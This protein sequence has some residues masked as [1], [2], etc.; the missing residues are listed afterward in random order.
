[1]VDVLLNLKSS[2]HE[3]RCS[4]EYMKDLQKCLQRTYQIAQE[5]MKRA[6]IRAKGHYDLRVRE[7]VPEASDLVLVKL[8]GLTGKHKLADKWESEPY[9]V[10]R[11][12]DPAMPVYV[13]KCCDGEG[14]ERALHQNMFPLALPQADR[15]ADELG[16]RATSDTDAESSGSDPHMQTHSGLAR[17]VEQ[18]SSESNDDVRY[19]DVPE[20]EVISYDSDNDIQPR[21][22]H[23]V[24]R[25]PSA[26]ELSSD[27]EIPE[28]ENVLGMARMVCTP[29]QFPHHS[30]R[31]SL[32]LYGVI[33]PRDV[34]RSMTVCYEMLISCSHS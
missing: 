18:S 25:R 26:K 7:N 15:T 27:D 24:P 3:K 10:I 13:V 8:V 29:R 12:P 22:V 17:V 2:E 34:R 20:V 4:T 11:K 31:T 23:V 19:I 33:F 6:S 28:Q 5:A 14:H 9:E 1:M 16:A 30:G 21:N 32:M